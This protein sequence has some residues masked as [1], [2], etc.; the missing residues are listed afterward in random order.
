MAGFERARRAFSRRVERDLAEARE[1]ARIAQI[2]AARVLEEADR[3]A[4]AEE[5]LSAAR[6]AERTRAA[7]LSPGEQARVRGLGAQGTIAA[8]DDEWAE[9]D[10]RGK[11][12]RVPRSELERASAPASGH[13]TAEG[14][15]R[16]TAVSAS[17]P[18]SSASSDL[19]GSVPEIN[20]IGQ[21]LDD[22]AE[23]VEKALDRALLSGATHLRV[24]HGHGT[25]RLRR[26]LRERLRAH[27]SVA[28]LRA[29]DK[30]EG[31]DGATVVELR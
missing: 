12:L 15:R 2:S 8:L 27:P 10:V 17:R 19:A 18:P 25:G 5:V 23:E 13:A 26:G 6:E 16:R 4:A 28:S 1:N 7:G 21:R 11:R 9:L 3:D 30:N 22:A 29:G 24:I 31:G 20:V 14:T